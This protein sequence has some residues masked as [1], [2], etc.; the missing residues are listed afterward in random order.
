VKPQRYSSTFYLT[1]ALDG[2]KKTRY[3]KLVGLQA[4]SGPVRKV[5]PPPPW[6]LFLYSLFCS[7]FHPYLFVCLTVLRFASLSLFATHTHTYIHASGGISFC[8]LFCS[9]LYPY[10]FLFLD[11]PEFC[12]FLTLLTT[13]ISMPPPPVGFLFCSPY[14]ICTTSSSSFCLLSLLYNTHNTNMHAPSGIRTR[15]S[16]SL[17]FIPRGDWDRRDSIPG[18]SSP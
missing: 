10:L 1:S 2:G 9:V 12:L 6:Y 18:P 14:F 3:R 13:K 15:N 5:S 17:C 16:S 4:R 7:V 8:I 11:C